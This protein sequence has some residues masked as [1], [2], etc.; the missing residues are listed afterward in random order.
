MSLWDNIG[1]IWSMLASFG[2]YGSKWD[3]T[4]PNG[5][6]LVQMG[7]TWSFL[8]IPLPLEHKPSLARIPNPFEPKMNQAGILSLL[9]SL[10]EPA[11]LELFGSSQLL[12]EPGSSTLT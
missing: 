6:I 2:G 3:N 12:L 9:S 1:K 7:T 4:G 10:A 8:E 11:Q 5:T